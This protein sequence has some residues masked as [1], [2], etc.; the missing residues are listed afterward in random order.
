MEINFSSSRARLISCRQTEKY[1]LLK[2]MH[3]SLKLRGRILLFILYTVVVAIEVISLKIYVVKYGDLVEL[4][5]S[6]NSSSG[7]PPHGEATQIMCRL[8]LSGRY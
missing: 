2:R 4:N 1:C 6:I 7:G 5:I 3:G 8:Y